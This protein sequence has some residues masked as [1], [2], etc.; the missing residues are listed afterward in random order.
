MTMTATHRGNRSR[1]S[2]CGERGLKSYGV[3]ASK[4]MELS[5]PVR[6]AWVEILGK[7][8]HSASP[9]KS[10]P[11]R[12]AWVEIYVFAVSSKNAASLPVRGAW[13]EICRLNNLTLKLN[14]RSPCGERGLKSPSLRPPLR[15]KRRSPCGERGLKYTRSI[16]RSGFQYV[17]PRAGSVG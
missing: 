14:C 2:P 10:L 9:S 12:G 8:I 11:V 6:G 1:R 4:W 7:I 13:V 3:K 17:A 16:E 5:L 15:Q